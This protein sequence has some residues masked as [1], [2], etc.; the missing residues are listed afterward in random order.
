MGGDLGSEGLPGEP[1]LRPE[2]EVRVEHRVGRACG[3]LGWDA[4]PLPGQVSSWDVNWAVGTG[5]LGEDRGCPLQSQA[6]L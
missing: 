3:T 5:S 1:P 4:G 2:R 6:R